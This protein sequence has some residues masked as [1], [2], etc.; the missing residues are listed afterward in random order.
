MSTKTRFEKE[1]WGNSEMAYYI[2]YT[3]RH[4]HQHVEEHKVNIPWSKNISGSCMVLTPDSLIKNF[5]VIKKC[6][7]CKFECLIYGMLW[8]KNKRPKLNTQADSIHLKL[9]TWVSAFMLIY[10]LTFNICKYAFPLF[11]IYSFDNDDMKSSKPHV[12]FIIV[13]FLAEM[14]F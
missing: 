12:V 9:F 13:N 7:H 5:K 3:C 6:R 2:G 4:F 14:F 1:A 11:L 8:I 10:F